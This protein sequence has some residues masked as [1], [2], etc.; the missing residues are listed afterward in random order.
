MF[1]LGTLLIG[2][3]IGS[4][5]LNT[6]RGLT[7][8]ERRGGYEGGGGGGRKGVEG[9]NRGNMILV[10]CRE[11][12]LEFDTISKWNKL[13]KVLLVRHAALYLFFYLLYMSEFKFK[14]KVIKLWS[15]SAAWLFC[16]SIKL[17]DGQSYGIS[18]LRYP[19]IVAEH[20]PLDKGNVGSESGWR[21]G[22]AFLFC[23]PPSPPPPPPYI[24]SQL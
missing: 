10:N 21:L 7:N 23:L 17:D 4:L 13:C 19:Y 3:C 24:T 8:P 18:N 6:V 16:N 14:I 5:Y 1:W 15:Q 12:N 20:V 2:D 11:A 9:L 22:R